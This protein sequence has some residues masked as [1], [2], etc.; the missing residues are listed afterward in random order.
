MAKTSVPASHFSTKL[1]T[2]HKDGKVTDSYVSR[3]NTLFG[4]FKKASDMT[5]EYDDRLI[6][7]LMEL[8]AHGVYFKRGVYNIAL[9]KAG[10]VQ[11][12]TSFDPI[13][14]GNTIGVGCK[15]LTSEEIQ[16]RICEVIMAVS[17]IYA[18]AM[19]KQAEVHELYRKATTNPTYIHNPRKRTWVIQQAQAMIRDNRNFITPE[20]EDTVLTYMIGGA[21]DPAGKKTRA[22]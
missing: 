12:V 4:R 18:S 15:T 3:A 6:S 9:G 5:T 17:A 2:Y 8:D 22:W 19:H 11:A 13:Q 1:G 7:L 14:H 20:M 10:L 21:M 16:K